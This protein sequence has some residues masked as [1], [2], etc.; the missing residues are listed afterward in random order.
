MKEIG[1]IGFGRI[2]SYLYDRITKNQTL[3]IS[4]VLE[5]VPEKVKKIDDSLIISDIKE[6]NE[7]NADLVVEAADFRAVREYAHKVLRKT[8]MMILS[9]TALSDEKF[10]NELLSICQRSKT[11]MYIPHGALLG[12]E[13]IFDARES[14]SSITITTTKNPR[15]IDFDFAGGPKREDI[16]KRTVLFDGSAREICSKYPRN[17]NSHAVVALAGIG[18]DRTHSVLIADPDSDDALQ[19]VKA[20]GGGTALEIKRSSAI[21]GVTGEYTLVSLYGSI[22][23]A[24]V[25]PSG[26]AVV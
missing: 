7:K 14:L 17:V 25:S 20:E 18:F 4:F 3:N 8:D 1:L 5:P 9:A 26:I 13:G 12:M 22:V 19:C 11:K 23:R 21:K 10:T 6:L 24:L 16:T 15:N 2:G